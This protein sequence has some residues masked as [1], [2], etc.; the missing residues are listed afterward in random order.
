MFTQAIYFSA[1]LIAVVIVAHF[2]FALARRSRYAAIKPRSGLIEKLVY[3]ALIVATFD[4]SAS[5]IVSMLKDGHMLGWALWFH[6]TA[7]GAFVAL[8]AMAAVLWA[9]A[10]RFACWA[11]ADSQRVERYATFTKITFWVLL[12]TGAVA[13]ATILASM[14]FL[15]QHSQELAIGIHRYAGLALTAAAVLHLYSLIVVRLI[16]P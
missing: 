7:A 6:L 14:F 13:I 4:V 10:S 8:L 5:A 16:R 15:N 2:M 1:V 11:K 9:E 12:L 3:L